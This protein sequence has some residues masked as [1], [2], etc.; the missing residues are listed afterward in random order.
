M[1]VRAAAAV[2][3]ARLSGRQELKRLE[4]AHAEAALPMEQILTSLGLVHALGRDVS[5]DLLE[6]LRNDLK[7]ES[8]EY[9]RLTQEDIVAELRES[10]HETAKLMA[11]SWDRVY[12]ATPHY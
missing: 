4:R 12:V 6:N 1:S 7:I 11:S 10:A 9:R 2:A 3:L 8:Y 5:E